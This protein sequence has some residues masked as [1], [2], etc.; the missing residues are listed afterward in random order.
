MNSLIKSFLSLALLLAFAPLAMAMAAEKLMSFADADAYAQDQLPRD[1]KAYY[2]ELKDEQAKIAVVEGYEAGKKNLK[3]KEQMQAFIDDLKKDAKDKANKAKGALKGFNEN[4]G[5]GLWFN[6]D[7]VKARWEKDAAGKVEVVAVPLAVLGGIWATLYATVPAVKQKTQE[8]G[9]WLKVQYN[10][11]AAYF[12]ANPTHGYAAAGLGAAAIGGGLW[13]T[14]AFSGD[15]VTEE[16]VKKAEEVA[17]KAAD[18][19]AELKK[20]LQEKQ[21]EAA[22]KAKK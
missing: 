21:E 1:I 8:L 5:T 15:S 2:D 3:T 17:Q 14:G 7:A 11:G 6:K 20:K 22:K 4:H 13:Y 18:K 16:G 10:K 9:N 12:K 19:A